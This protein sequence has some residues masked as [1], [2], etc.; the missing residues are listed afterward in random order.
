MKKIINFSTWA[1]IM[2][3]GVALSVSTMRLVTDN[4]VNFLC[5]AAGVGFTFLIAGLVLINFKK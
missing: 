3:I 5:F 1:L 4:A 2:V